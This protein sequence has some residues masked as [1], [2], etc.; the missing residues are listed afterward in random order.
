[1]G[2]ARVVVPVAFAIGAYIFSRAEQLN[3]QER[4]E[5]RAKLEKEM[6]QERIREDLVIN[7]L[8]RIST[9]LFSNNL[10]KS[11]SNEEVRQIAR[12]HTLSLLR[13]LDGKRK[14]VIIKFLY[15]AGLVGDDPIIELSKANLEEAELD[16]LDLQGITLKNANLRGAKLQGVNFNNADLRGVDLTRVELKYA[17]ITNAKLTGAILR[18]ASCNHIRAT[19]ADSRFADL[20]KQI[21]RVGSTKIEPRIQFLMSVT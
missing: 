3:R 20:E 4:E 10:S 13:V 7:Y 17:N 15:E 2:L 1:M 19:S 14:G 6:E 21:W 18:W 9:L 8:D 11:N 12:A 5:R 16:Y